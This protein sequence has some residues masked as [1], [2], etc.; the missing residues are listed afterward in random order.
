LGAISIEVNVVGF[1]SVT[2]IGILMM[3]LFY[4]WL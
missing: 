4:L 2:A 3:V 1:I